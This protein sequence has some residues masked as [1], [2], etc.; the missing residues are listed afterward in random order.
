ML[1][2]TLLRTGFRD[3]RR[4]PLPTTLMVLGVAVGVAVVVAINLAIAIAGRRF[5][6]CTEA[7]VGRATHRIP[8]GPPGPPGAPHQHPPQ[9]DAVP[10]SAAPAEVA[11]LVS[12]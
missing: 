7:G 6:R 2:R 1:T 9:A 5:A 12:Q 3:L 11:P 8:G 4:R 10:H